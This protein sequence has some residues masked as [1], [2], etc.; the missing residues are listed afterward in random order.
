M[1]VEPHL[2][3]RSLQWKLHRIILKTFLSKTIRL[4]KMKHVFKHSQVVEN[5]SEDIVIPCC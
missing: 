2:R 3:V 5:N 1:E 4:E